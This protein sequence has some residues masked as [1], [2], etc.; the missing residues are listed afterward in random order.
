MFPSCSAH[1][2]SS[3][4]ALIAARRYCWTAKCKAQRTAKLIRTVLISKKLGKKIKPGQRVTIQVRNP[5]GSLTEPF[6]F[7]APRPL[8]R[9]EP[10]LDGKLNY[11][12]GIYSIDRG[13][14]TGASNH[15]NRQ[16]EVG[17]VE[18]VEELGA[19]LKCMIVAKAK[20]LIQRQVEI[21]ESVA[22]R[23]VAT[24][25]TV[26]L[27]DEEI[28]HITP[29]SAIP[30]RRG[31]CPTKKVSPS[32]LAGLSVRLPSTLASSGRFRVKGCPD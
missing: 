26:P 7:T 12:R 9:L 23:R 1:S 14:K 20:S 13:A 21:N 27:E 32:I 17:P 11:A 30:M 22:A 10:V 3:A 5:D 4:R 6:I 8:K 2:L 31:P 24:D 15:A 25:K 19:H 28:I 16:P 29:L 18:Q